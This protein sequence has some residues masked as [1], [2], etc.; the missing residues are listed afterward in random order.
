MDTKSRT[1]AI[2]AIALALMGALT[3]T[4]VTAGTPHHGSAGDVIA[5][6]TADI[7]INDGER[8]SDAAVYTVRSYLWVSGNDIRKRSEADTT[9]VRMDSYGGAQVY[10][11]SSTGYHYFF[12]P[13]TL[14][15]VLYGQNVTLERVDIYYLVYSPGEFGR[16]DR[17]ALRIQTQ[18][19]DGIDLVVDDTDYNSP[20][21]SSYSLI[22]TAN[23]ELSSDRGVIYLGFR[24]YL[25]GTDE[26]VQIGGV[27]LT[28]L[29][30][31]WRTYL[32]ATLRAFP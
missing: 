5:A 6:E 22:P 10:S 12:L 23:N 29:H 21:A 9:D 30:E 26:Y 8:S 16:I 24:A 7:S 20:I 1:W 3:T 27:R 25:P 15:G 28:L 11:G 32:P 17:T 18:A 2:L 19:G 31:Y 4:R 14:P 13:I